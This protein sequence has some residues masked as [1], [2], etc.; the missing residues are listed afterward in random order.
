M[1]DA[2]GDCGLSESPATSPTQSSAHAGQRWTGS[3]PLKITWA[4]L[5]AAIAAAFCGGA[6]ASGSLVAAVIVPVALIPLAAVS[7]Y[8][9]WRT[10]VE[11]RA[12]GTVTV[13]TVLRTHRIP[14]VQIFRMRRSE[15]GLR[16]TLI[17]GRIITAGVLQTGLW[18]RR[19]SRPDQAASA[20][21]A[22]TQAIEAA[23][24]AQPAETTAAIDAAAPVRTKRMVR[25]LIVTAV[26]GPAIL[27]ASFFVPDAGINLDGRL[28]WIGVCYTVLSLLAAYSLLRFAVP[29]AGKARA[30]PGPHRARLHR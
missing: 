15:Y 16:I 27:I 14:A 5:E 6:I 3:T 13:R 21:S 22:I 20:I 11:L 25:R 30:A 1:S 10:S 8:R 26:A 9:F 18:R 7:W 2:S 29:G 23:R 28:R 17:D 24:A 4:V 12:D 19:S